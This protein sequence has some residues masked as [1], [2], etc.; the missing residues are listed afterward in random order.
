MASIGTIKSKYPSVFTNDSG[1]IRR[2]RQLCAR[3]MTLHE[4]LHLYDI[5]RQAFSNDITT[6]NIN[7]SSRSLNS[8]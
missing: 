7:T 8:K 1:M 2:N 4:L 6:R 3:Y 5:Q